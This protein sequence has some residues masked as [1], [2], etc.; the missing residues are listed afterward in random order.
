MRK[1]LFVFALCLLC[2]SAS[3][4]D[5][6]LWFSD[7]TG[8]PGTANTIAGG[9]TAAG[10]SGTQASSSANFAALLGGGGF[11][12]AI[13]SEQ[14]C[15]SADASVSA[16]LASF[17]AGGGHVIGFT[18]YSSSPLLGI[19]GAADIGQNYSSFS[20]LGDPLFN[21]LPGT[22]GLYNPSYGVFSIDLLAGAGATCYGQTAH[23]ACAVVGFNGNFINGQLPDTFSVGGDGT[24][25]VANELGAVATPEPGSLVLLG[26]GMLGLAGTL[27]RKLAR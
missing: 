27:R 24:Q 21:G 2:T 5:S 4:A 6:V 15:F 23:G 26:S 10:D 17:V 7:Y 18:W 22:V 19:A 12:T 1:L 13:F 14:C 3:F 11:Q 9:I 20:T 8:N 25:L 16:A